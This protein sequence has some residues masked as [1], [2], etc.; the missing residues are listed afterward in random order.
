VHEIAFSPNSPS[1]VRIRENFFCMSVRGLRSRRSP[2]QLE[3][4]PE[5]CSNASVGMVSL[6]GWDGG[7]VD[8]RI[9]L[10]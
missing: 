9:L 3:Q 2:A 5:I 8:G 1:F 10:I 4:M 7:I 6:C